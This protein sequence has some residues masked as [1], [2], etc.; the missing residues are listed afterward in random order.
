MSV[1]QRGLK[2]EDEVIT[3]EKE[4]EE[5]LKKYSNMG[6]NLKKMNAYETNMIF[7]TQFTPEKVNGPGSL[8]LEINPAQL[9]FVMNDN[10]NK[11]MMTN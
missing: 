5:A 11:S 7:K 8:K 4:L 6:S 3:H 10:L 1:T 2:D 9:P